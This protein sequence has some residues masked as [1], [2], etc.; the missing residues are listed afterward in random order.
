MSYE[1]FYF[2]S[3]SPLEPTYSEAFQKY[4]FPAYRVSVSTSPFTANIINE[5][6]TKLSQGMKR[7]EV[8]QI[9]PET[10][11]AIPKEHLK[12]VRRI[13]KLTGV[14]FSLH[15]PIIDPAGFTGE[16]WSE[17]TREQ[18]ERQMQ[19]VIERAHDL[20]P[21]GNVPV[22]FHATGGV[23]KFVTPRPKG[24]P[25][26]PG[27]RLFVIDRE[28][29][30]PVVLKFEPPPYK[31]LEKVKPEDAVNEV[32]RRY[33]D[34]HLSSIAW[35]ERR[36]KDLVKEGFSLVAPVLDALEKKEVS[37]EKLLPPQREALSEL[38]IGQT[39]CDNVAAHLKAY[40]NEALR[41]W[42]DEVKKRH[43]KELE[44]IKNEI[45]EIERNNL[46]EKDPLT[47]SEKLDRAIRTF[48]EIVKRN[49]PQ[50]YVPTDQFA[51]E[52]STETI[53]NVALNA[54]KRFKDKAPIIC[55]ENIMPNTVFSTGSELAQLVKES[56]KKFIEKAKKQGLSEA[57][58]R[59]AAEK[60]I[61]ATWDLGHAFM[62]RKYG[63]KPKDVIEETKK[64]A[65]FVKHV[66]ISDN[67]GFE[68]TELP[69]GMGKVPVKEMLKE[70]EKATKD[71]TSVIEAGDWWQHFKISP[72]PYAFEA[73]GSP[74]YTIYM[75]PFWE[76]VRSFY[77]LPAPYF[78]GY[79][80]MLP[81][82]HFSVYGAGFSALPLELG[83][84]KP[85]RGT[86][87]GTPME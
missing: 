20:D 77:G 33:W 40:Y 19:D 24:K 8:C 47:A 62:L 29:G 44:K 10:F 36:A 87:A 56:R 53:A 15:G 11:E 84:S 63:Y 73:L 85:R 45:A 13:G 83:G 6:A 12:E 9:R 38:R 71:F 81:E 31:P 1:N 7:I 5:V 82:E 76:Q 28:T 58:A 86:F 65:P 78:A 55:L 52:K 74:L 17:E 25:V 46:I 48:R 75:Q 61:G 54:Y 16:G 66:H 39:L 50:T 30:R 32:N 27:E 18:V 41:L 37:E 2:G 51:L 60:L 49:P 68:H 21:E 70:I 3:Y 59:E 34:S 4:R 14:E 35:E 80:M 22:T 79:G 67:F 72:M 57:E 64:V 42:P 23:P 43:A 26:K 69:P